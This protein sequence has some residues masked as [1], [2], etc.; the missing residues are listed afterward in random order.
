V[1]KLTT[2]RLYQLRDALAESDVESYIYFENTG[3]RCGYP[4]AWAR[5]R[6]GVVRELCAMP[7]LSTEYAE[8]NSCVGIIE[9]I[10]SISFD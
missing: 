6:H 1:I 3:G 10:K 9:R 8:D 7:T 2:E 5:D 4:F